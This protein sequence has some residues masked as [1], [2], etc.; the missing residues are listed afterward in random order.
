MNN[1]PSSLP[2]L[3]HLEAFH[4]PE[5]WVSRN[6]SNATYLM[7][8][9]D[10]SWRTFRSEANE[11]NEA[12]CFS[13]KHF[14]AEHHESHFYFLCATNI[15]RHK[16]AS[17]TREMILLKAFLDSF[18]AFLRKWNVIYFLRLLFRQTECQWRWHSHGNLFISPK[19]VRLKWIIDVAFMNAP[20]LSQVNKLYLST[21][22][23]AL[24]RLQRVVMFLKCKFFIQSNAERHVSVIACSLRSQKREK[25]KRW[26]V[27]ANK[28][29]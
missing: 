6:M 23:R 14:C 4:W 7:L 19:A 1:V 15:S 26:S 3:S 29:C 17:C 21:N 13:M 12:K 16:R 18:L 24:K 20:R 9:F 28:S 10:R 5:K 22:R 25:N 8:F 27:G 2:F 11:L